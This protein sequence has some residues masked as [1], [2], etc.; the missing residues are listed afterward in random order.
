VDEAEWAA[1]RDPR[2]MLSYH[3]MK[4]APRRLRLLAVACVRRV[5]PAD[6][7]FG[8]VLDTAER[9]ADATADRPE[10]LAARKAARNA[11]RNAVKDGHPHA[12]A[13]RVLLLLTDDAMEGLTAA[14]SSARPLGGPDGE[15]AECDL[16]RCV[17]GNPYRT[18]AFDPSWRTSTVVALA[19][20][21]YEEQAFDRLPILADA[22]ED[23][24][25]ANQDVLAH[26]R[27]SGLHARGCWVIDGA[28]GK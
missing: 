4:K 20:G 27:G 17:C 10:F 23:A 8:Q 26:C 9:Y 11:A 14:I 21:I 16:I 28:L 1:C 18:T 7:P 19:R 22:L 25:C 3:R 5:A 15:A 2:R 12:A 6:A 13:A 24:G